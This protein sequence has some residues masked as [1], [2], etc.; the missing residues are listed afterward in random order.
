[1]TQPLQLIKHSSPGGDSGTRAVLRAMHNVASGVEGSKNPY[2]RQL[3]IS[4]VRG[5]PERDQIGEAQAIARWIKAHIRFQ[6]ETGEVIQSGIVTLGWNGYNFNPA[7]A[8]GDC[9]DQA[10]LLGSMLGALGINYDFV[11]P[12]PENKRYH[13]FV[14]AYDKYTGKSVDLDTAWQGPPVVDSARQ[15]DKIQFMPFDGGTPT[16]GG[17][18]GILSGVEGI[19]STPFAQNIGQGLATKIAFPN[20]QYGQ[21]NMSTAPEAFSPASTVAA[22]SSGSV[23]GLPTNELLI[24]GAVFL[25][26]FLVMK[27]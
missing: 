15:F 14:R 8:G 5:V 22:A 27:K 6:N 26:I 24:F 1:M 9:D 18:S 4:I 10:V 20:A 25:A 3:G 21:V 2:I 11:A 19:L 7:A 12:G 23:F 13:V 16:L 17:F